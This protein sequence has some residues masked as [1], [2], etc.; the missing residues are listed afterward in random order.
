VAANVAPKLGIQATLANKSA[1]ALT[2]P[3]GLFPKSAFS[4]DTKTLDFR[5]DSPLRAFYLVNESG[6]D[7]VPATTALTQGMEITREFLDASGKAT[8]KV[9]LGEEVT[10]HLRFRAIGRP[11]IDD[12]V[13]VDLL[14]G[15]FDVVV[16]NAAPED[17]PLLAA[18]PR[19][20]D[21]NDESE[22]EGEG[23]G[24]LCLWLTSRTRG[25]PNFADLR[26]DRVVVYGR[27]TDVV[28]E[29]S[30]RIKAT[31]VGSYVIPAAFG[32]SMYDTKLRARAVAGRITVERP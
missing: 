9:K 25:F 10:V 31:N 26:E 16:P 28:Q 15:G 14:P 20:G 29:F 4:A 11:S 5:T 22:T 1:V 24:C 13:L 19:E 21:G 27:V 3:A 6:F 2:L 8:T 18:S 7:R 23:S 30:Y 12:A 32:E 17:Q